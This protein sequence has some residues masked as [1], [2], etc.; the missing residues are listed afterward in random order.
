[1]AS[2]R[3]DEE[4]EKNVFVVVGGGD[5]SREYR[6]GNWTLDETMVLIQAE[7]MDCERRAQRL[8]ELPRGSSSRPQEM[9]WGW[10]EDRCWGHGCH[11][12][13]N[14]CNGRWDNL[15]RDYKKV[16]AYE[17][18]SSVGG[19]P[20][21]SYWNLEKNARKERNLP[22]NVLPEVY[23]ALTEVVQRKRSGGASAAAPGRPTEEKRRCGP[24]AGSPA[25]RHARPVAAPA[26]FSSAANAFSN[27][28]VVIFLPSHCYRSAFWHAVIAQIPKIRHSKQEEVRHKDL[29]SMER[30]KAKLE[31]SKSVM[32]MQS[33]DGLAA[34]INK[35]ASS[36][37]GLA[38]GRVQKL[39][40]K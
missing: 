21:L 17:T 39:Q 26:L 6:K 28:P 18:S 15:M 35:L 32:G 34:A 38:T 8:K 29:I 40:N 37:L 25:P 36:I 7:K 4:M 20:D 3:K 27:L 2:Q 10:V 9:R 11:R 31:E 23:E 30:R 12:S 1:M 16:R 14:Q 22:S 19:N 24:G 33:M 13:Q 5:K